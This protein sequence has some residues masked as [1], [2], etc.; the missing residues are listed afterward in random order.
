MPHSCQKGLPVKR[1]GRSKFHT[2]TCDA[3]QAALDRLLEKQERAHGNFV[4]TL[5]RA[6]ESLQKAKDPVVTYDEALTLPFVGPTIAKMIVP[7]EKTPRPKA[8][9]IALS[10]VSPDAG[11]SCIVRKTLPTAINI[12]INHQSAGNDGTSRKRTLEPAMVEKKT[13]KQLAVEQAQARALNWKNQRMVWRVVLLIDVREQERNKMRSACQQSGIPTEE[14]TLPIGDMAWIAQ[15]TQGGKV[16]E[17]LLVGTIVERKSAE[18][19]KASL[20]GTRYMEQRKRLKETG[21]AQV[22]FLIEGDITKDQH[23]CP[24]DTLLSALWEIRL[25]TGFQILQTKHMDDTVV[26]LKRMHRRILQRT[27]PAVFTSSEAL[28]NFS[29]VA[30]Q[31]DVRPSDER[32]ILAQNR[33]HRRKRMQSLMEM[34]FDCDPT[35]PFGTQRFMTYSE[36]KAIV[37]RDR[38]ITNRRVGSLHGFMLK[39]VSTVNARKIVR[40]QELY[41]TTCHLLEAYDSVP[42][43]HRWELLSEVVVSEGARTS[44]VGPRSSAELHVAYGLAMRDDEPLVH[45]Q[46]TL[47]ATKTAVA[48][49]QFAKENTMPCTAEAVRKGPPPVNE[50]LVADTCPAKSYS[51]GLATNPME[52]IL[53]KYPTS[54][55]DS[56]PER[57]QQSNN[58]PPSP[59]N[60]IIQ[61]LDSDDDDEDISSRPS[62]FATST[63]VAASTP[64]LLKDPPQADKARVSE[65]ETCSLTAA[66]RHLDDFPS[67]FES[68][69]PFE[70]QTPKPTIQ[71]LDDDSDD[72]DLRPIFSQTSSV[73][74]FTKEVIEID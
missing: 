25:H 34:T 29:Q 23:R 22:V 24:A 30:V 64:S 4:F 44:K 62:Q 59:E 68:F 67:S 43:Y 52:S 46:G 27:F 7:P 50:N 51:A 17:E 40:L 3:N 41:P 33:R 42:K 61:M 45:R 9:S 71:L 69:L 53:E 16:V 1:T 20:F 2:A 12:N 54:F 55:E 47:P 26:T 8:A 6:I 70:R 72:E 21:I 11:E 63:T 15:G 73:R 14:R 37:E 57:R 19:L 5:K 39:Q 13:K 28:P 35:P 31:S 48:T 56:P 49:A 18:D 60:S 65:T 66:D 58:N 38:E 10:G 32:E 74:T 36:L